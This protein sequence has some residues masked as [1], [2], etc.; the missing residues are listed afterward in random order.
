MQFLH[1]DVHVIYGSV[2]TIIDC[3]VIIDCVEIRLYSIHTHVQL[4]PH[5]ILA[6]F[7]LLKLDQV[8]V[9]VN[10]GKLGFK[11]CAIIIDVVDNDLFD[12]RESVFDGLF[13]RKNRG[14]CR[15]VRQNGLVSEPVN[16]FEF[17]EL[18]LM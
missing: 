12:S 13:E 3:T 10:L 5:A 11:C 17:A 4:R 15:S 18:D 2:S 7:I 8:R 9:V 1:I 16:S 14:N 6:H